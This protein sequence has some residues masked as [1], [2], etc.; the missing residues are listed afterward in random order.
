MCNLNVPY[1]CFIFIMLKNLLIFFSDAVA[2]LSLII[3]RGFY[4][5]KFFTSLAYRI[6]ANLLF[7]SRI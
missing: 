1:I 4:L 7:L 6:Q 2:N 3:S 5:P